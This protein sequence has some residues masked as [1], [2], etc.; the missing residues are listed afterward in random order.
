MAKN[1]RRVAGPQPNESPKERIDRELGEL[2]D[3]VR[4]ILPGVEI[5][6]GFLIILPFSEGFRDITGYQRSL[7]LASL[8]CVSAGL[9]LC[10]A[11]TTYHRLRFREGDKVNLLFLS[12]RFVIGAAVL[13]ACGIALSVYLVVQTMFAG[14]VAAVIAA[15]NAA[16]FGWFWFGLPLLRRARDSG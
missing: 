10:I 11:P 14:T 8:L 15:L 2:I 5:L 13:V 16:W 12:N 9:A 3:E 7:Y 1:E 6:F 4:I